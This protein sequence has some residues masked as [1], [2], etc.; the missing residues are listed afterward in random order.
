MIRFNQE[1]KHYLDK[2]F[3]IMSHYES[4]SVISLS[5]YPIV[6]G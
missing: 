6:I 3:E 1:D 2:N 5:R 4:E